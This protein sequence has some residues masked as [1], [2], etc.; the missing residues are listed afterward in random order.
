MSLTILDLIQDLPNLVADYKPEYVYNH[1]YLTIVTDVSA[2]LPIHTD[3]DINGRVLVS[4]T[5]GDVIRDWGNKTLDEIVD[6]EKSN[7]KLMWSNSPIQE[8]DE[9]AAFIPDLVI[10]CLSLVDNGNQVT[11]SALRNKY[12][13][14][15]VVNSFTK[16]K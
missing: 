13:S 15:L 14:S 2:K 11:F 7:F 9:K 8:G 12:G 16:N 10:R 3:F 5:R 4:G 1:T 6:F